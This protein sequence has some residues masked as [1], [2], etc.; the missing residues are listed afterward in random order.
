MLKL[1]IPENC[2]EF[3]EYYDGLQAKIGK[4]SVLDELLAGK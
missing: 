2:Q 4:L 3:K 1:E